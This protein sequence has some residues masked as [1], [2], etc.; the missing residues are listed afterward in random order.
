MPSA[1]TTTV[2]CWYDGQYIYVDVVGRDGDTPCELSLTADDGT[3][4]YEA[5]ASELSQGVYVG[6]H[7]AFHVEILIYGLGLYTGDYKI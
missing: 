4:Q 6:A 7:Q 1:E 2:D 3:Q 5:T